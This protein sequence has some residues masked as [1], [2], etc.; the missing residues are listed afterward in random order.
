MNIK[1]IKSRHIIPWNKEVEY[2]LKTYCPVCGYSIFE[3]YHRERGAIFYHHT[4]VA[5]RQR[6]KH[7]ITISAARSK[8]EVSRIEHTKFRKKY[9]FFLYPKIKSGLRWK[10]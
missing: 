5:L 6:L 7:H 4:E 3:S 9:T 8:S 1:I 2:G 10:F